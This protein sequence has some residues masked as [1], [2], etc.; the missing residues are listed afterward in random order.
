MMKKLIRALAASFAP[1]PRYRFVGRCQTNDS[2]TAFTYR[3]GAGFPGSVN[4]S[5]PASIEPSQM[6]PEAPALMYGVAMVP[7]ADNPGMIRQIGAG[8]GALTK[9]YGVAV[10]PYPIQQT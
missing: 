1:A 7:S 10:R 3:M 6:D 4:R 5:H 8:D 2:Y 9:I